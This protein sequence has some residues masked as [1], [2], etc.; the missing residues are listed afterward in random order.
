MAITLKQTC[1]KGF[2]FVYNQFLSN[3]D[4][5]RSAVSVCECVCLSL[6]SKM[7]CFLQ[8]RAAGSAQLILMS[9]FSAALRR[10]MGLA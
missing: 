10:E 1:L 8:F 3:F 2:G 7:R 4:V 5:V 6:L 9:A